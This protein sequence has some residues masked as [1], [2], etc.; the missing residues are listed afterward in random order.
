MP[1]SAYTALNTSGQTVT[2]SLA[3]RYTS[4]GGDRADNADLILTFA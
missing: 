1:T 2:G 3:L 4:W